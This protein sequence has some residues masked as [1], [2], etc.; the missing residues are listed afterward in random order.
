MIVKN[1]DKI[2]AHVCCS[3]LCSEF[4]RLVVT[5]QSYVKSKHSRILQ[6]VSGKAFPLE[7]GNVVSGFWHSRARSVVICAAHYYMSKITRKKT[8][9]QCQGA[10]H[11]PQ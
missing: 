1:Y 9:L 6:L 10:L 11:L 4:L 3:P 5:N 8:G 7:L 2:S